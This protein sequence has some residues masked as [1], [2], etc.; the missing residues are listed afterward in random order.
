MWGGMGGGRANTW[1]E[2]I[3]GENVIQQVEMKLGEELT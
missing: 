2:L 1:R 3:Q